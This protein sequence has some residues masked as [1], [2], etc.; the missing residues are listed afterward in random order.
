[1]SERSYWDRFINRR[2]S[3]RRAIAA[4]GALTASAA[5]LAAC[6]GDDDDDDAAGGG[7]SGG[8]GGGSG[9]SASPSSGGSAAPS[10]G[11]IK[12]GGVFRKDMVAEDPAH[13][14]LHQAA[15]FLVTEEFTLA[16]NQLTRFSE[17]EL[18]V[19]DP[20]L[21]ES[22]SQDDELTLTFK[23]NQAN[24]HDGAPFTSADVKATLERVKSPP[25]G[26]TSVRSSWL[27]PIDSIETPD[28]RTVV[29]H[30]SRPS[31]FMFTSFAT[32]PM[33]I[34]AAKDIAVDPHW[35]ETNVNG[36]GPFIFDDVQQGVR[37]SFR[38]NPDYFLAGKPYLDRV[39]FNII[40]EPV[41]AFA[42]WKGGEL[43]MYGPQAVD[44]PEIE[45]T[46]DATYVKTGGTS[47]WVMTVPT[48]KDPWTDER[49]WSALA[50]SVNKEDFNQAQFLG[51]TAFSSPMP[52]GSEWG[53]S[54]EELLQFPGYKGLGDGQ[55]SDMDAR[56]AEAKK[57][58]SAA[59]FDLSRR[60]ELFSWDSGSFSVWMEVVLDGL[61]N[62]GLENTNLTLVDRGT[63]DERLFNRDWGDLAGNSRNAAAPDPTPVFAD[64]YIKGAGRHYSDLVI[65]EVEDLFVRQEA[66][67]DRQARSGLVNQMNKAFL[68][69]WQLDISCYTVQNEALWN[70]VKDK[71]PEYGSMY[72]A[73][74]YDA[75]WLDK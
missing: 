47:Y 58:F 60:L 57:L 42:A 25:E 31:A 70:Y 24:F 20:D 27:D 13:F 75:L 32:T 16:Y 29:L 48:Q 8:S 34:Y 61:R 14:D 54:E 43:D 46:A 66:T 21:A 15:S 23:L 74:K 67:L 40:P 71:G 64:N 56:W 55:E 44:V 22:W 35:H 1:M 4:T 37:Y 5:F 11:D 17:S 52:P 50:L 62:A 38:K 73:R 53:L 72:Q 63:Y 28:D 33:G 26:V 68:A 19:I 36:T 18:G 39:E 45:G 10:G 30:S 3:R 65:P 51:T 2:V 12:T 7:D 69:K 49:L 59:N 41:A 6:G 9:A